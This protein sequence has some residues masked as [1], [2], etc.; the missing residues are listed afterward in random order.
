MDEE[1]GKYSPFI[2]NDVGRLIYPMNTRILSFG[3]GEKITIFCH[4]T[5]KR[6]NTVKAKSIGLNLSKNT[7]GIE[8]ECK[9]TAFYHQDQM[10]TSMN[11]AT[12][13]RVMEPEIIKE[14]QSDCSKGYGAD[15]ESDALDV[16]LVKV[17]WIFNGHFEEQV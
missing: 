1:G 17:G 2:L 13:T 12:C 11:K 9:G 14:E 6:P 8:L 3:Q 15:G 10:V 5:D 7:E 4:G 16:S